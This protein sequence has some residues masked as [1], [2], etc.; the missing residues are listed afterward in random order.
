MVED[1]E[2]AERL[3]ERQAKLLEDTPECPK[4]GEVVDH[5]KWYG[6]KLYDNEEKKDEMA[7]RVC[8]SVDMI[9]YECPWC[10]EVLFETVKDAREFLK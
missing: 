5:L 7:E 4:C 9:I 6:V 3:G 2:S 1:K 10:G 8:S